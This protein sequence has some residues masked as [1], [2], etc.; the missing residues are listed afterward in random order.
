MVG[1]WSQYT[2]SHSHSHSL[3][4]ESL[5]VQMVVNSVVHGHN[6]IKETV[7][8][9]LEMYTSELSSLSWVQV[10]CIITIGGTFCVFR[11][12]FQPQPFG[13]RALGLV[14]MGPFIPCL[15]ELL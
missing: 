11:I 9:A 13:K 4:F 2:Y 7:R 6:S 3:Q 12:D 14:L 15:S 10:N 8:L 1:V 5:T